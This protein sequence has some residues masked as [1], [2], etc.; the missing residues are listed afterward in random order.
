M[1]NNLRLDIETLEDELRMAI[2]KEIRKSAAI[3]EFGEI[4]LIPKDSD[5]TSKTLYPAVWLEVHNAG[6]YDNTQEDIEISPISR[7]SVTIETYTTG[8]KRRSQNIRLADFM[9]YILQTNQKLTKYYNRG[10]NLDQNNEISSLVDGVNRRVLRFSAFV[11]NAS[12]LIFYRR[13]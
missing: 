7:I 1:A 13:R 6:T 12:N 11:D 9:T 3:K 2:K 5:L 8:D 10:L 4:H